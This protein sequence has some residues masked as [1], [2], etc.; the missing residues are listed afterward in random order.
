MSDLLDPMKNPVT[1][2]VP[3]FLLS[4]AVELAALKWLDHDDNTTGYAFKDTRTS[5]SMG[6]GSLVF[7][8]VFKVG[9]FFVYNALYTHLALWQLPTD[10]WWFW[11][12]LTLGLDLAYY[13]NHRFVHR[14]NIGWAAH[15]AHHSS[16]YMNF[17]TA[18]RQKWN[19]WFEFF[20]WLPLPLLGF[21]PWALYVAFSF[22][23]IYQFF[24]HTEAIDKLPRPIEF[25]FNTPSHHRVHHGSDPEYLDKNYAGILIIWD[26][27]FGTFQPELHRPTYGLTHPV[28]TYNVL[29]L[30]YG[31]FADILRQV[32]TTPRWRDKLGY[33]FGP[34]GWTPT[35]D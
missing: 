2:A 15:Q 34:P 14:V 19:P 16:E 35:T 1:Y 13:C 12:V 11:V 30:Q 25:V 3:F 24:V 29:T 8:T 31:P 26:R 7:L 21:A 28:E 33:L 22:N 5:L 4:I 20:F 18:L 17:G 23:L 9:T 6:V 32:R 10:T 27:M